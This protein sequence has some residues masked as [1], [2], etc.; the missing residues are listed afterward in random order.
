CAPVHDA[1]ARGAVQ[2]VISGVTPAHA[3][4]FDGGMK[5][6][7]GRL[8]EQLGVGAVAGNAGEEVAIVAGA[9]GIVVAVI[10]GGEP[11]IGQIPADAM[12]EV[13]LDAELDA[14]AGRTSGVAVGGAAGEYLVGAGDDFIPDP[15]VEQGEVQP[16][17]VVAPLQTQ[18][19]I[20][21]DA[22][23]EG[24]VHAGTVFPIG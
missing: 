23:L 3:L 9:V 15:A 22:G 13:L 24:R 17:L 14:P 19:A 8:P 6:R 12:G 21:R 4:G 11:G 1:V 10:T 20:P 7:P 18:F 16:G 5:A 2:V